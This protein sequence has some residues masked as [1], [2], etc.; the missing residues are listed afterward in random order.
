MSTGS[1]RKTACPERVCGLC[2][3]K[4]YGLHR[5]T[6]RRAPDNA[7]EWAAR[8]FVRAF[9]VIRHGGKAQIA[10]RHFAFRTCD[11]HMIAD[12]GLRGAV[13]HLGNLQTDAVP[14]IDDNG[15][16]Q[17]QEGVGRV[18]FGNA[19]RDQHGGIIR[20]PQ[21]QQGLIRIPDG[22]GVARLEA[23]GIGHQQPHM[24]IGD[25]LQH[26]QRRIGLHL[27]QNELMFLL[28]AGKAAR[29]VNDLVRLYG[30]ASQAGINFDCVVLCHNSAAVTGVRRLVLGCPR[31]RVSVGAGSAAWSVS[32]LKKVKR[33]AAA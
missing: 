33:E 24:R 28:E 19:D 31:S 7:L 5:N 27:K 20:M 29:E 23:V 12:A 15:A 26:Q 9:V 30:T 4:N 32:S 3:I 22:D 8:L 13:A 21:A 11:T 16:H 14:V 2:L 6:R 1:G 17:V 10:L 18:A 25:A